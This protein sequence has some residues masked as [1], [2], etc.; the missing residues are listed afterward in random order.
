MLPLIFDDFY[1]HRSTKES[2]GMGLPFCRRTVQG[3][4]GSVECF[5]EE[6]EFTEVVMTFPRLKN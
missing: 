6:G 1:S 3:F 5:S 2:N 4:G